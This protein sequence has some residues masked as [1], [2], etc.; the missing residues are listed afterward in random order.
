MAALVDLAAMREIAVQQGKN[1]AKIDSKCPA[2]LVVDH[3][4][5]VD[6]SHIEKLAAKQQLQREQ[7]LKAQEQQ[8]IQQ[9]HVQTFPPF[10]SGEVY[11]YH[12]PMQHH[13]DFS[14]H[15]GVPS[16]P[17]PPLMGAPA[18]AGGASALVRPSVTAPPTVESRGIYLFT[19]MYY[20]S[21]THLQL[22]TSVC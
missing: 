11:Y 14:G 18:P 2:D 7:E 19:S 3:S 16:A 5:Q 12:H 1:P 21:P 20:Y 8:Q 22:L 15:P 4:V 9:Q 17:P 6:F 10:Y 13:V